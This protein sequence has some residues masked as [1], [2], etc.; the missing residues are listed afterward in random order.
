[1][2]AGGDDLLARSM[3]PKATTTPVSIAVSDTL[4]GL[5]PLTAALT[6]VVGVR[7]LVGV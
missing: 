7:L 1:M 4:G 3:A 5:P 2:V 6:I